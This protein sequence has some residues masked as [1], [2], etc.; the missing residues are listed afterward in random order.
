VANAE[1]KMPINFITKD[2]FHITNIC[3]DYL[4]P[5]IHGEDTPPFKNGL[6]QFVKLKN[7]PVRKKLKEKFKLN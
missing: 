1:K 5:L 3:R 2:G 7:L 4:S 6:P